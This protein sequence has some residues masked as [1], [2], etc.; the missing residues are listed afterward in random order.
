MV[1]VWPSLPPL[2]HAQ[3]HILF[4]ESCLLGLLGNLSQTLVSSQAKGIPPKFSF[5]LS[6]QLK[7]LA[8]I[9]A[10][11]LHPC[12]PG[13]SHHQDPFFPSLYLSWC[14]FH[15]RVFHVSLQDLGA[16]IFA[17]LCSEPNCDLDFVKAPVT[18]SGLCMFFFFLVSIWISSAITYFY[19]SISCCP[20]RACEAA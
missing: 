16:F 18:R 4:S 12:L 14:C 15:L 6:S 1:Q 17:P 20:W 9:L 8:P 19:I 13:L 7:S 5:L 3:Q 2:W 10:G 11:G